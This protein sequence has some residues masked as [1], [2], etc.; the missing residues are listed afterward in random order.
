MVLTQEVD[1]PTEDP[2][3]KED[4]VVSTKEAIVVLIR[5]LHL[6]SSPMELSA[7][8]QKVTLLSN[9]PIWPDS[10]NSTEES[11]SKTKLK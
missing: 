8:N 5:A 1:L 11:T 7:I 2:T 4:Q 6:M 10:P 3:I 9:A